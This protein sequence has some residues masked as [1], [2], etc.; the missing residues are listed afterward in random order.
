M[1]VVVLMLPVDVSASA[2]MSI[3]SI[4]PAS[5]SLTVPENY[6]YSHQKIRFQVETYYNQLENRRKSNQTVET[7]KINKIGAYTWF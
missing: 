2:S 4:S 1:S 5:D 3:S 6:K 7:L